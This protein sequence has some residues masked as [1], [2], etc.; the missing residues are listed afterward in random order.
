MLT[1]VLFIG[2]VATLYLLIQHNITAIMLLGSVFKIFLIKLGQQ[3]IK[4]R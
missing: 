2:Y 1:L 4:S 3:H